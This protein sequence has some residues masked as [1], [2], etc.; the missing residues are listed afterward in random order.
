LQ[1]KFTSSAFT[2]PLRDLLRKAA[3]ETAPVSSFPFSIRFVRF[4][5]TANAAKKSKS[6]MYSALPFHSARQ[7]EGFY[8]KAPEYS[9]EDEKEM[10]EHTVVYYG[11]HR[12]ATK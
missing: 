11:D 2:P 9:R 6:Y 1:T 8:Q 3:R 12:D 7:R 4:E 5:A 10:L